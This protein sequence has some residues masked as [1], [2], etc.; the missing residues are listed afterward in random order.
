MALDPPVYPPEEKEG[1]EGEITTGLD[2]GGDETPSHAAPQ[3]DATEENHAVQQPTATSTTANDTSSTPEL[4]P[5]LAA[6]WIDTFNELTDEQ[7]SFIRNAERTYSAGEV[8]RALGA[9]AGQIEKGKEISRPAAYVKKVLTRSTN[10]MIGDAIT[11]SQHRQPAP[12][13]PAPRHRS[14]PAASRPT[15]AESTEEERRRKYAILTP[16]PT[17]TITRP[18]DPRAAAVSELRTHAASVA[19]PGHATRIERIID[20]AAESRMD[21]DTIRRCLDELTTAGPVTAPA[22]KR[23]LNARPMEIA[24]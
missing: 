24:A 23:A 21:P 5:A 14:A 2:G 19:Q 8:L 16:A 6:A 17:P 9:T 18:V 1:G 11:A 12:P 4:P 22:F 7:R 13:T 20:D 3:V 15:F 10:A